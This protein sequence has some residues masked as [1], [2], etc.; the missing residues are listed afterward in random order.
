MLENPHLTE[1][2]VQRTA[3]IRLTIPRAEIRNVM[4]P[5]ISEVL[6]AVQAQGMK[7]A[8]PV[9]ARHFRMDPGTFD[10]E[11]G[12]PVSGAFPATG[13]VIPGELPAETVARVT[14]RG[15]YEGLHSAW[16]EFDRWVAAEGHKGATHLWECYVSGPE[17]SSDPNSWR[18]ELNRPLVA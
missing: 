3:V 15:P 14:Y 17:S 16:G 8:G 1:T 4:G 12:V 7:P 11:V 18:T 9:F 10:F 5:A 2:A 13:R 6:A